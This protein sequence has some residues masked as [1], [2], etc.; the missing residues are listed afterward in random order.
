MTERRPCIFCS[1][2]L[3]PGCLACG[4][5]GYVE[6][7]QDPEPVARATDPVTSWD[8]ARD[9]KALSGRNRQMAYR[10]LQDAGERGLTDFELADITGVAQTS[11]GKRRKEL[12]DAG[13]V[14]A[15]DMTRPAPSGSA[16]RVW[17]VAA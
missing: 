7:T 16:A 5:R 11:I 2:N 14:V 15:T 3:R 12:Q 10:A 8:A 1:S 9:A 4:G 6:S 13:Y 17:R